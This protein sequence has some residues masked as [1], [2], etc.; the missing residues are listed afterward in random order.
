M[1][2]HADLIDQLGGGTLLA[3]TLFGGIGEKG[4]HR[5]AVYKWK[6]NGIPW[7]WRPT[8]ERLARDRG[9]TLPAGFMLPAGNGEPSPADLTAA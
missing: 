8:I 7:R 9:L 5:E 4:K 6:Q 2:A 1:Q 3:V